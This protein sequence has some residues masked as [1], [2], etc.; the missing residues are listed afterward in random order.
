MDSNQYL[1]VRFLGGHRVSLDGDPVDGFNSA[2]TRALFAYL[3]VTQIEQPRQQLAGLFWGE[4]TEAKAQTN[5]RKSLAN[6]RKLFGERITASRS[7]LRFTPDSNTLVDLHRFEAGLKQLQAGDSR[8]LADS[9]TYYQ[10]DFLAGLYVAGAPEFERWMLSRQALLREA[11]VDLLEALVQHHGRRGEYLPAISSARRLLELEP[12]RE[13]SH[14]GLM[15]LYAWQDQTNAALAQFKTCRKVLQDELGI[16]VSPETYELYE[17]IRDRASHRHNLPG[18]ASPFFGRS[19]SVAQV[20]SQLAHPDCRLLTIL[21][22]GGVGKTRVLRRVCRKIG[23]RFLEGVYFVDLSGIDSD[24]E[25]IAALFAVL[26]TQIP[27]RDVPLQG[28]IDFLDQKEILLA[29]DNFEQLFE[30]RSSLAEIVSGC[31]NVKIVL[32]SRRRL[33]LQV[34]Q[35]FPLSGLAYQTA[36]SPQLAE[37]QDWPQALQFF[38]ARLGQSPGVPFTQESLAAAQKICELVE[39]LPLAI[40]L[41]A[42]SAQSLP[43]TFVRDGIQQHLDHLVVSD[44]S[45]PERHRSLRATFEHS[46]NALAAQEQDYFRQIS[47]FRGGFSYQALREVL[48]AKPQLLRAL[49]DRSLIER[50]DDSHYAVHE[51]LRQYARDEL[52]DDDAQNQLVKDQH[53]AYFLAWLAGLE[54]DI[55]GDAGR[56]ARQAIGLDIEN[57]Y[58]AWR[59]ALVEGQTERLASCARALGNYTA[60]ARTPETRRMLEQAIEGLEPGPAVAELLNGLSHVLI[61]LGFPDEAE[62]AAEQGLEIAL[63]GS[64]LEIQAQHYRRLIHIQENSKGAFDQAKLLLQ[65]LEAILPEL[66]AP[67]ALA[68][69]AAGFRGNIARRQGEYDAALAHYQKALELT[70]RQG[71][72]YREVSMVHMIAVM[73]DQHGSYDEAKQH[74]LQAIELAERIGFESS[75]GGNETGLGSIALRQG[76]Y[77]GAHEHFEAAFRYYRGIGNRERTAIAQCNLSRTSE[78]R[79][80][81]ADGQRVLSEALEFFEARDNRYMMGRIRNEMGLSLIGLGDY[82]SAQAR[83]DEAIEILTG[84]DASLFVWQAHWRYARVALQA[85]DLARAQ[86]QA[87]LAAAFMSEHHSREDSCATYWVLA[88]VAFMIQDLP[89]AQDALDQARALAPDPG[90]EADINLLAGLMA[91]A[92]GKDDTARTTLTAARDTRTALGQDYLLPE[93]WAALA[94]T[95]SGSEYAELLTAADAMKAMP[96]PGLRFPELF[97]QHLAG[98]LP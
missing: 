56:A 55:L 11:A 60:M 41:A 84:I 31:P 83:L 3:V 46:W 58:S 15:Q 47:V 85:G 79:G 30:T 2:K 93:I 9:A 32:T 19:E 6:L 95:A 42:A 88:A 66:E 1:E 96:V 74:Y 13:A 81:F 91:L 24:H 70:R 28:L 4:M 78:V 26:S 36:R 44:P 22:P 34:E 29:L 25:L 97:S 48:G 21:G 14:R 12:W 50:I 90:W 33:E 37:S 86:E 87:A 8:A 68:G 43:V 27:S 35:R 51:L 54:H 94:Q 98:L 72:R 80:R 62:R 23:P 40:E 61:V 17:R 73:L 67:E 38:E 7:S 75:R 92:E 49:Q 52:A 69:A 20:M 76:D 64:N 10:G 65:K 63:A 5:L 77:R 82:E 57:I 59:W 71:N 18:D 53:S 39:G 89:S 16:D 45:L